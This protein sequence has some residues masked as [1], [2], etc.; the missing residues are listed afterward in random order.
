MNKVDIAITEIFDGREKFANL[1][2]VMDMA[3]K[4]DK[5]DFVKLLI[6]FDFNFDDYLR[7]PDKLL[8]LYNHF[9]N[10]KDCKEAPVFHLLTDVKFIRSDLLDKIK[11]LIQKRIKLIDLKLN[12]PI[13]QLFVWSILC[14]KPNIAKILLTITTDQIALCLLASIIYKIFSDHF[15][16]LEVERLFKEHSEYFNIYLQ[17]LKFNF[18]IFF[19]KGN[20]NI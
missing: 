17:V 20:L 12:D 18:S 6:D 1:N 5:P 10:K 8:E 19:S 14:N 4:T 11:F 9:K 13:V 2:S 15:N 16:D 3:L 7:K